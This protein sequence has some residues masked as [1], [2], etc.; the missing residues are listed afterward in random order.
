MNRPPPPP[1][2]FRIKESYRVRYEEVDAQG[3]VNHAQYAHYF[4]GARVAY[5]RAM[6]FDA[7]NITT[8]KVQPVVVHLDVDFLLPARFDDH[9]DVWCRCGKIGESSFVFEYQV[10]NGMTQALQAKGHTV[11]VTL[12]LEDLKPVRVPEDL[13]R[14]IAKI[15]QW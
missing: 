4:T 3:I 14:R 10:V 13:R 11:L 6:G 9:M 2:G 8:D 1:T 5:F 12:N 7:A 15:E